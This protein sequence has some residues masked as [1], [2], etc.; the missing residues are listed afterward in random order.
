MVIQFYN[1]FRLVTEKMII[2]IL[3][4]IKMTLFVIYF[5][6]QVV[7]MTTPTL[8]LIDN[9]TSI[10]QNWHKLPENTT[11][12]DYSKTKVRKIKHAQFLNDN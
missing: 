11:L 10:D 7:G 2:L 5:V 9:S 8:I 3:V 6:V 12:R 4:A 1:V